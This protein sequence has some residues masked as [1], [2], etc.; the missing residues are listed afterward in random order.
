MTGCIAAGSATILS[1]SEGGSGCTELLVVEFTVGPVDVAGAAT[2]WFTVDD[3]AKLAA[4]AV[5]DAVPAAALAED[6]DPLPGRF[7]LGAPSK[8]YKKF[9]ISYQLHI[10]SLLLPSVSQNVSGTIQS[11]KVSCM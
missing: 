9:L 3:A 1:V 11:F 5:A 7:W 6:A 2:V 4:E 8:S 10:A